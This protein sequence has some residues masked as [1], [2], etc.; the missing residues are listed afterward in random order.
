LWL[1]VAGCWSI[2]GGA[3]GH[4]G[5]VPVDQSPGTRHAAYCPAQHPTS[6][7]AASTEASTAAGQCSAVSVPL[8]MGLRQ[9]VSLQQAIEQQPRSHDNVASLLQRP[10]LVLVALS[11]IGALQNNHRSFLHSLA[12][13]PL[14]YCSPRHQLI[15]GLRQP[16]MTTPGQ[17]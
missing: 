6:Q 11:R 8:I 4:T 1:L 12:L 2:D 14:F 5:S 3:G 17:Q 9:S 10:H 16:L 7:N 15:S 13:S